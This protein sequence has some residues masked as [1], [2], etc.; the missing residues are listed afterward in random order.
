M[1]QGWSDGG[2]GRTGMELREGKMELAELMT[3]RIADRN[4]AEG[5]EDR[6]GVELREGRMGQGWSSG[7]GG[8]GRNRA[9]GRKDRAGKELRKEVRA[10]M[11]RREGRM[12]Q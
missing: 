12:A 6:T 9:D 3:G 1:G 10:P 7:R 4:R 5:V 8:L 11:E 2:E